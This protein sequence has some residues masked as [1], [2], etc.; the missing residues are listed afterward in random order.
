[1]S[2]HNQQLPSAT[3]AS[4]PTRTA[5]AFR[6]AL[7]NRG[8]VAC[9]VLLA[10]MTAGFHVLFWGRKF[11]KLPLPL[12]TPLS[13]L[14]QERLAPYKLIRP[15]EIQPDI[16]NQLGTDQY[17]QWI[18]QEPRSSKEQEAGRIVTLFVTYYTG[19]PD[20]VPH[21]PDACYAGA[22]YERKSESYDEVIVTSGG[23]PIVVPVQVLEF[24]KR[25]QLSQNERVVL[26]TFH[27]NGQFRKDRT[28]VRLAIGS[29]TDRYAYFSKLEVG[30]DLEPGRVSKEQAV[31]AAKRFIQVAIP[32]LL[33]DHWP[34]WEA[35]NR[36]PSTPPSNEGG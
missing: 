1:M 15:I 20:A 21:I 28:E 35:A 16:L 5:K 36:R 14:R 10:V 9:A 23:R 18:L 34:D 4:A 3:G 19:L 6:D 8:F 22:G 11:T 30:L 33:E 31:E 26:Y 29:L 27:S 25:S 32:V 2:D 13:Q 17:V 7:R 24:E 12:K